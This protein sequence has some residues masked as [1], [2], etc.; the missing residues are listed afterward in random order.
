[1]EWGEAESDG[2]FRLL[3]EIDSPVELPALPNPFT[4][5][6]VRDIIIWIVG[7]A[8][9]GSTMIMLLMGMVGFG[10]PRV[11]EFFP[12]TVYCF[13]LGMICWIARQNQRAGIDPDR[14]MGSP[15]DRFR[16]GRLVPLVLALFMLSLISLAIFA[17]II[18]QL[19][20]A[21]DWLAEYTGASESTS[22]ERSLLHRAVV[23]LILAP[24]LEE[25]VFRGYFLHRF[26]VKWSQRTAIWVSSILFAILHPHI[27]GSLIFGLVACCLYLRTRSLLVP[28]VLHAIYNT[29]PTFF[30]ALGKLL[31]SLTSD[32]SPEAAIPPEAAADPGVMLAAIGCMGL[33]TMIVLI[34]TCIYLFRFIRANWPE[35][36]RIMPYFA[37]ADDPDRH[38]IWKPR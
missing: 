36:D 12:I 13:Y 19:E 30:M 24:V 29:I 7:V 5:V 35:D 27:L 22:M 26:T 6:R 28:M 33:V 21:P 18:S 23:A 38:V 25:F 37:E 15:P 14:L 2:R 8:F 10:P 9:L 16:Y 17:A 34:P 32:S 4:R 31:P 1:V 11:E 3:I 20:S